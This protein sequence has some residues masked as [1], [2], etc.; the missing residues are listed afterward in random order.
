[1]EERRFLL[2]AALVVEQKHETQKMTAKESVG[3]ASL[4]HLDGMRV[5]LVAIW[6]CEPI[7]WPLVGRKDTTVWWLERLVCQNDMFCVL[8]WFERGGA[9]LA[10]RRLPRL[11]FPLRMAD[12]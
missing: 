1:M 8:H 6:N 11:V 9:K 5:K 2:V 3:R 4:F 7:S 10:M 12:I